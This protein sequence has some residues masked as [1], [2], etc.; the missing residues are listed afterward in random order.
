MTTDLEPQPGHQVVHGLSMFTAAAQKRIAVKLG[1]S[2]PGASQEATLAALARM[3]G[4]PAHRQILEGLLAAQEWSVLGL[5]P[6]RLHPIRIKSVLTALREGGWEGWKALESVSLL[7]SCGCLLP[8]GPPSSSQRLGID[9]GADIHRWLKQRVQLA[10]CAH[11]WA[12]EHAP[13]SLAPTE[14]PSFVRG[15][16]LLDF[17]RVMFLTVAETGRQPVR[18]RADGLPYQ[19]DQRRL[20]KAL[21]SQGIAR[22]NGARI[23]TEPSALAWLALS[24][25]VT[26]GLLDEVS[27][28]LRRS[29]SADELLRGPLEEQLPSLFAAWLQGR[30]NDFG[31]IPT[32]HASY[33]HSC[34]PWLR[35]EQFYDSYSHDLT[36][37]RLEAARE[38]ICGAIEE[39]TAPDPH[40]W[41]SIEGLARLIRRHAPDLLFDRTNDYDFVGIDHFWPKNTSFRRPYP[42]VQRR[43]EGAPIGA[44]ARYLSLD[45]DWME[46]E[47]AFVRQVVAET[48]RWL[49]VTE[50]DEPPSAG[51]PQR[52]HLTTLGRHILLG[53]PLVLEQN[54]VTGR[55]IVQPSF[56]VVVVDAINNW[57]LLA[58]LDVFAERRALDRAATFQLTQSALLRGLDRGWTGQRVIETLEAACG[59]PLPQNVR[60]SVEEWAALYEALTVHEAATLLEADNPAQ[61]ERWLADPELATV[62]GRRLGATA[63]LV[64]ARHRD[65]VVGRV[66]QRAQGLHTIDYA[67]PPR[68]VLEARDPDLLEVAD[69]VADPY[70][71]Y[72]LG[73]LAELLADSGEKVVYRITP[74]SVRRA[75]SHGWRT[76]AQLDFLKTA[77]RGPLPPELVA[78]LLGWSGQAPPLRAE[79][80]VAVELPS[81]LLGWAELGKIR[82]IGELIRALLTPTLALVSPADLDR[83]RE[84]LEERGLRLEK[85]PIAE[86]EVNVPRDSLSQSLRAWRLSQPAPVGLGD[87]TRPVGGRS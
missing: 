87:G 47:G 10:P 33:S 11:D 67:N 25:S 77:A 66:R 75:A 71:R 84:E 81:N 55:V 46:V 5:L 73:A 54:R 34:D 64:P 43:I 72:C 13:L 38:I 27:G 41:Y 7:L 76:A 51:E 40:A 15:S 68:A 37:E 4:S 29:G 23:A 78:R 61:L 60:Y 31:A 63:V 62:L 56:E 44:Q 1:L 24:A 57:S 59:T 22:A 39:I 16:A 12:K 26:L 69:G 6:L 53:A 3:I 70:L 65:L 36:L 82:P 9:V 48:F 14:A 28:S 19:A 85:G 20:M 42:G 21:A 86:F 49:G 17:Q 32:L 80:L 83:L 74:E 79:A 35:S 2:L 18:T 8:L 58:Q 45:T 52:F 30:F 50:T